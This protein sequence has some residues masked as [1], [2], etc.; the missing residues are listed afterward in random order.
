[1]HQKEALYKWEYIKYHFGLC[2][3]EYNK[4]LGTVSAQ[5]CHDIVCH[6]EDLWE[7]CNVHYR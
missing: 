6:T 5:C 3:F 1:M 2:G 7:V 4:D